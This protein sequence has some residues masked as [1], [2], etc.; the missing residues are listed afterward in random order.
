MKYITTLLLLS[1]I[2]VSCSWE[3]PSEQWE[4]T[5]NNTK[6]EVTN[7]PE[8]EG[9]FQQS[10]NT[11]STSLSEDVE[12]DIKDSE[13]VYIELDSE[14]TSS[15]NAA[16]Q[17][18]GQ[19]VTIKKSWNYEFSGTL[20]D[21]QIAVETE[22]EKAVQI[23]LNGIEVT[24]LQ[25]SPIVVE[26]ANQTIITLADNSVNT[27]EDANKY[28]L[29]D[30]GPNAALS[31]KDDVVIR[32][33]G[34][35]NITA[36]YNDGISSNDDIYILWWNINIIAV[37]DGIRWK[38]SL[39]IYGWSIVIEAGEDWLKSNNEEEG[40]IKI[41]GGDIEISAG[42]DAIT[43]TMEVVINGGNT[44]VTKSYEWIESQSIT[45]NGWD[46]YLTSSDDGVN[47]VSSVDTG[48]WREEAEDIFLTITGWN[49]TLNSNGD[50]LDSN[51]NISMTWWNVV[52]HGPIES[53]NGALD[54]NGEYMILGG[55]LIA[56]W[57]SG[58]AAAPSEGSVQNSVLIWL[59]AEYPAW[60]KISIKNNN[61]E[62]IFNL[63]SMKVF[64]A[65]VVSSQDLVL[66]SEYVLE[67]DNTVIEN[68]SI[69]DIVTQVWEIQTRWRGRR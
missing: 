9:T 50:G 34:T 41:H 6:Q 54:F 18:S 46:T 36:N 33:D 26:N 15:D 52:V 13:T 49:L 8:S 48:L 19:R 38:N 68:F 1:A 17:I 21:G 56:I 28:S 51:G 44:N 11:Q 10:D 24:S 40:T 67:I 7:T 16:I 37:D 30:D 12:L 66:N 62:E 47:V 5:Q 14:N 2:L 59:A 57:S 58:M 69:T 25:G 45:I 64:Q 3:A 27:L 29:D 35:L 22:D 55:N 60:S 43:A 31:S 39:E 42:D 20:S 63:E 4:V 61:E 32:G 23:I 65:I 53:N